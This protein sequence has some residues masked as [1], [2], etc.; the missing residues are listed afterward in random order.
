M[1]QPLNIFISYAH[2]DE[3]YKDELRSHLKPLERRKL[4]KIWDD[5]QIDAGDGWLAAIEAAMEN[6]QLAVMLVSKA[7]INSEFIQT[8]E[9]ARLETRRAESDIRII[10]IILNHCLWK[11][12]GISAI[13]VLPKN[14]KPIITFPE[15][16]GARDEVWVSIA[17]KVLSW[18][19][20]H[21]A[22]QQNPENTKAVAATLLRVATTSN[23]T[24]TTNATITRM[25]MPNPFNPWHPAT[26][27][28]FVG[29]SELIN[30]LQQS[31]DAGHSVSLVAD[32]RMG[33]TS[34]LTIWGQRVESTGRVVRF[35]SGY[36]PE[37]VS[38]KAIVERICGTTIPNEDPDAAADEIA[39]WAGITCTPDKPVLVLLDEADSFLVKQPQRFIER[40][41][42]MVAQKRLCL[43]LATRRKINEIYKEAEHPPPFAINTLKVQRIG[44]LE[45]SEAD[46]IIAQ[47][48][49]LFN[50]EIV[51]LL[52]RWAGRHPL[53]LTLL[54][55]HFWRVRQQDGETQEALDV[56]FDEASERLG[57][58]WRTLTAKEKTA[59]TN[60]L[61][62]QP[63]TDGSL[64][65][66]GLVVRV[67][68]QDK[69]FGEVFENGS[70]KY[71]HQK[72]TLF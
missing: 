66:R 24:P 71:S 63:L 6:C 37:G 40:L 72:Q 8:R 69:L 55:Y 5:Q 43:V 35:L 48:Q 32:W 16:N 47:G 67:G 22:K 45:Q 27:S 41:H 68:S 2:A 70:E 23:T 18:A 46:Y 29:R 1:T 36:G 17:E 53:Y 34:L 38:C 51:A 9:L 14:G 61:N 21:M 54:G 4:I 12:E 52:H 30:D 58:L 20:A 10:P 50:E 28:R 3:S 57:E 15:K 44:L 19:T 62:G 25:A 7:F 56:F 26:D 11:S 42:Q 59:L 49:K 31:F 39:K 64:R 33:K 65:L 13:Q 60:V